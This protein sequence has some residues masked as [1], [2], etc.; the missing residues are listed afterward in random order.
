M[1]AEKVLVKKSVHTNTALHSSTSPVVT[2]PGNVASLEM[3]ETH[4]ISG[5][6][7]YLK[8]IQY[9]IVYILHQVQLHVKFNYKGIVVICTV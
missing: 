9:I 1:L 6:R 8:H 4:K 2:Q 5:F 3:L 7:E